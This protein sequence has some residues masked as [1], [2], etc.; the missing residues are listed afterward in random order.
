MFLGALALLFVQMRG[1]AYAA[2]FASP[3][4]GAALVL[5][6]RQLRIPPVHFGAAMLA[7]VI[8]VV[9]APFAAR[10]IAGLAAPP[11]TPTRCCA[12]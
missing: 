3:I 2:A 8:L 4:I 7:G 9:G 11:A 12:T 5:L 1:V 6:A 10:G